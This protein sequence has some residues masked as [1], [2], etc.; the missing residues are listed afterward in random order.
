MVLRTHDL[1]VG[2]R[3]A[4]WREVSGRMVAPMDLRRRETGDFWA[5]ARL[6]DLGTVL[7]SRTTCPAYEAVRTPRLIRQSD[8]ESYQLALN[9]RGRSSVSQGRQ[10]A[11]LGRMDMMLFDTSRPFHGQVVPEGTFAE[12][13]L[14]AFPRALLPV[15]ECQVRRLIAT[16]CRAT[17]GS[18]RSSPVS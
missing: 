3:F 11:C 9:L 14:M 10:D 16:P 17:R 5:A 13:V 15:P 12:G 6:I 2:E 1:P 7:V 18:A 8:L 4:F